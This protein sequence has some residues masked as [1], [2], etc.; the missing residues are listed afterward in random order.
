LGSSGTYTEPVAQ[1]WEGRDLRRTM[2]LTL[3][4]A[5]LLDGVLQLEPIMFTRAFGTQIIVPVA[6]GNPGFIAHS[7]IWSG[8]EIADHAVLANSFFAGIQLLLA[9]GI[10]W[11]PTVKLALAASIV[12]SA[13]VWWIGEGLG[14]VLTR[15]ASPI[16]GAPGAVFLYGLLAVI[17]WPVEGSGERDPVTGRSLATQRL[18]KLPAAGCWL[19]LWLFLAYSDVVS[20]IR[21]PSALSGSVAGMEPGEPQWLRSV[22]S[23]TVSVLSGHAIAVCVPV[24]IVLVAIAGSVLAGERFVRPAIV[25]AVVFAAV[26]WVVAEDFGGI[27]T[28][29][30]TDPNTGPLLIL[31]ALSY[32]PLRQ[33]RTR[34]TLNATGVRPTVAVTVNRQ[35]PAASLS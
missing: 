11:R 29:T 13:G 5:W 18:G 22:N 8:N 12:W 21:S 4:A 34:R 35:T 2:Q 30:A 15:T 19:V 26:I 6:T 23:A 33:P 10:A 25:G 17:L 28:G 32:W 1:N 14:G 31:V 3:A 20:A 16:N 9:L 24:A 7:I 27:L